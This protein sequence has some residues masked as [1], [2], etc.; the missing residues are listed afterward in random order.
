[1][2]L[3]AERRAMTRGHRE[4]F[5][6]TPSHFCVPVQSGVAIS[7]GVKLNH[8]RAQPIRGVEL[9]RLGFDEERDPNARLAQ[10]AHET[11]Q[12]VV[13]SGSIEPAFGGPLL[14]PLRHDAGGVRSVAERDRQHLVGRRHFKVERQCDLGR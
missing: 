14:T 1:M 2:Y 11:L 13:P 10:F 5:Q 6:V 3:E 9:A 12:M 4:P 7:A 8:R